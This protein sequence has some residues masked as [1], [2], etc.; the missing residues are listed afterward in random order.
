MTPMYSFIKFGK[1]ASKLHG[2]AVVQN[3]KQ[4]LLLSVTLPYSVYLFVTIDLR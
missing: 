2:T 1:K 4:S 3:K